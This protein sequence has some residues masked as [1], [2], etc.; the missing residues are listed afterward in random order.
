LDRHPFAKGRA[1]LTSLVTASGIGRGITRSALEDR[2]LSFLNA[3]SLPL[4]RTN[5]HVDV[6]D[7]LIECDCAWPEARL[8]VELDGRAAHDNTRAFEGDRTRDRLLAA[9]GWRVVRITW[10]QL[11][12]DAPALAADLAKAL[13]SDPAWS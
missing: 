11:H 4:P 7:H 5:F 3:H 2:F 10:R 8:V 9:A 1:K 13:A 12:E 6:G